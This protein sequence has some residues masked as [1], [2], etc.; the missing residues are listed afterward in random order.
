MAELLIRPIHNDH[1]AIADLLIP[2]A[3]ATLAS[4]RRPISRLVVEAQLAN[5][6]PQYRE[7]AAEAGTPLIIDPR[8][9]LLQVATDP[10]ISWAKLPYASDAAWGDRLANPF[11]LGPI[12]EAVVDFQIDHGASAIVS[13]YFYAQSPEDPAFEATLQSLRMTVRHLRARRINLPLVAVLAGSHRG[14]ARSQTYSDGVDRFA[15][16]AL[17]YGPQL[18]A[19]ALSPNGTGKDGQSKVTQLFDT[20]QRLKGTGATVIAWRQGFYG[21]ALVAAGLDGYET[22]AGVGEKT[23]FKSWHQSVKPGSRG[24]DGGGSPWPVYSETLA[25]SIPGPRMRALLEDPTARSLVMCRDERCCPHGAASM[26]SKANRRQHN[27]RSRAKA[28]RELEQMPHKQWRLHQIAKDAHAATVTTMKI[29][30]IL[31]QLGGAEDTLPTTGHE[32]LAHVAEMLSRA[33]ASHAA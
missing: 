21:P 17:D 3:R 10:K 29:N 13:P 12:V 20:A 15:L 24:G 27:I 2:A 1:V 32:A 11:E 5:N 18:L 19:F 30:K 7:A 4:V 33:Q 23:D 8:T 25:R 22:G 9:D 6:Q 31:H 26:V 28:L 14:F 16:T